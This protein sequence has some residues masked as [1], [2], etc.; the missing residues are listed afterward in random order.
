[1]TVVWTVNQSCI[2]TV[3]PACRALRRSA[4]LGLVFVFGAVFLLGGLAAFFDVEERA[5]PFGR[6]GDDDV[7][8]AL[9]E[10]V[11]GLTVG[12]TIGRSRNW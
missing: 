2:C 9:R 10:R 7:A 1:M 12:A 8:A 3:T 5:L 6:R 11:T 4:G